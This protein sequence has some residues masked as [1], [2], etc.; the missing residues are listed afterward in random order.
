MKSIEMCFCIFFTFLAA[1]F[2]NLNATTEMEEFNFKFITLS[3]AAWQLRNLFVKEGKIMYD[4]SCVA[5]YHC[6]YCSSSLSNYYFLEKFLS[7][8]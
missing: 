2:S 3:K 5:G 1:S 8:I 4:R 6:Y 7:W